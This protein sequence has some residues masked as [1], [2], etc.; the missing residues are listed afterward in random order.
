[1]V[2]AV[3]IMVSIITLVVFLVC[4]ADFDLDDYSR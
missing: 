1:V 3:P 4:G 2:T